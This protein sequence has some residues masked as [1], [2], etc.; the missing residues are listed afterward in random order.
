VE[1]FEE[2]KNRFALEAHD[3]THPLTALRAP[4][5]TADPPLVRSAR[6]QPGS[7]G[8][9]IAPGGD[10]VGRIASCA[11]A[12]RAAATL[13]ARRPA[14]RGGGQRRAALV[15]A[16]ARRAAAYNAQT[17][18]PPPRA[19]PL[20]AARA[21]PTSPLPR[22]R[23]CETLLAAKGGDANMMELLSQMLLEGYGCTKD[24]AQARAR[25][26][27]R[28]VEGPR[29]ATPFFSFARAALHSADARLFFYRSQARYWHSAAHS[30]GARRLDGVYDAL[31]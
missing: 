19:L 23:F 9:L 8:T 27:A 22:H 29:D 7:C 1:H 12:R 13:A 18:P 15:R 4:A 16:R 30:R 20:I 5:S 2:T 6:G 17:M 14:G 21:F 28:V 10:R 11:D 31:P 25:H 3:A 24:T 26:S